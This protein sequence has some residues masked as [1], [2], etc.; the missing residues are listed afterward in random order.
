MMSVAEFRRQ[1]PIAEKRAYLFSGAIA[2]A[3]KSV[4]RE[5]ER[6][7]E[8][9][10]EAPLVNYDAVFAE[11][12][13]TRSAIGKILGVHGRDVALSENTSRASNTGVRILVGRGTGSNVVLDRTSYPSSRYPW[14]ALSDVEV[15]VA[16]HRAGEMARDAIAACVDDQTI[17]VVVSHVD[18]LTGFRHNL[19][20]LAEVCAKHNA[21][22]MVDVAQSAGVVPLPRCLEGIDIAVGTTMKWLLG[23]PGIGFLYV[24]PGLGADTVGLDVGYLGLAVEGEDWPQSKLPRRVTDSRRFELGLPNM[25]GLGAA[26]EGVELLLR[27]GVSA[28]SS[29]VSELAGLCI[30]GLTKAGI[31][32]RTPSDADSRAGVVAFEF[33][34]AEELAKYLRKVGVDVGGYSWGLCRVDPHAFNTLDDVHRLFDGLR[35]FMTSAPSAGSI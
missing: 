28:V 5:M 20:I 33:Q 29:R 26:A 22:L 12:A 35:A 15:R 24:R 31:A 13:R 25:P 6:W 4:R 9:W 8:Q 32:V 19:P 27:V 17:A 11:M 10:S 2:P 21:A 23:P 34:R 18:P 30:E 3:A 1:F 16:R 14:L 7:I